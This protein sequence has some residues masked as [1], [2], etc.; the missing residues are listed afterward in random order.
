MILPSQPSESDAGTTTI[1]DT[2]YDQDGESDDSMETGS[3]DGST[4]KAGART[5]V[6]ELVDVMDHSA[7]WYTPG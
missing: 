4:I 1:A 5:V 3:S 6:D 7:A 2:R